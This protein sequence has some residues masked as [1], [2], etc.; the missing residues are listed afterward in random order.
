MDEKFLNKQ[1]TYINTLL[2]QKRLKDAISELESTFWEAP[3]DELN[4][5]KMPYQ[6]MLQYM[7]EGAQD[8]QRY[9]LYNKLVKDTLEYTDKVFCKELD[10]VSSNTY[11]RKRREESDKINSSTYLG[12]LKTLEGFKDELA[13]GDLINDEEKLNT[14]LAR[15]E[16]ALS[17]LFLKAWLSDTWSVADKEEASSFL[18]SNL[19]IESDLSLFISAVTLASIQYFDAKKVSWLIDA[20]NK[21]SIFAS[22]RALVGLVMIIH[23]QNERLS[24]YPELNAKISFLLEDPKVEN[25]INSIYLQLLQAQETEKID[26]RMREE[27]IPG[28]IKN[29]SSL[30]D[31]KFGFEEG[32]DEL[33]DHNPDWANSFENSEADKMMKE[34]ANLQME[35]ADI[36]MSSF[37]MLKGYPFFYSIQNWFYPFEKNHSSVYNE[38]GGKDYKGSIVDLILNSGMFCNSDKYSLCFTFLHFPK[39]Q[40]DLMLSQLTEQQ[41]GGLEDEQKSMHLK[42]LSKKPQIISNQ[43]IHDLYRFYKLYRDHRDFKS[44]F[45]ETLKF[46]ELPQFNFLK[47]NSTYLFQIADFF[48]KNEHYDRAIE[49]Y[50]VLKETNDFS[51]DL[52]QKKGYCHQKLK[53]YDQAITAYIKADMIKADNIWTN[54]H[55]AICYRA[56]EQ[57]DK[58]LYYYQAVEKVQPENLSTL[59][60]I[61]MCYTSMEQ[62]DKALQYFFKMDFIKN[63][64]KKAWRAIGWCSFIS[65]KGKQA[66]R[67]Y[68]KRLNN[69]PLAIDYL[70]AGHVEWALG[71]LKKTVECYK[72]A[73]KGYGSK[74]E[75]IQFIEKDK[76]SLIKQGIPEADIPLLIDL[77]D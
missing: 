51:F 63:N 33:N 19:L 14:V 75:F 50:E 36:Y 35:G 54:S 9:T 64:N 61:G 74:N 77:L 3:K 4:N 1:Y 6:Y 37:S 27:I 11:H 13:V 45:S 25:L 5:I 43:Y 47:K 62:Y 38:F 7:L 71:N 68:Q 20:Y 40:R 29:A 28:M 53:Q 39:M 66:Q 55:L 58:A 67:Y 44:I 72:Q 57:Y 56:T 60:Y 31:L 10:K 69:K 46:Q 70:N 59:F 32:E 65:G 42:E 24:Y 23:L 18:E 12:L 26:K 34:M 73:I 76:P 21:Q 48:L 17:D 49:I 16:K 30:K 8:P 22:P 52:F 41:M 2:Q 15:H